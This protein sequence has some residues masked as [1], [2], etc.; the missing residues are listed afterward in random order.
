MASLK[1]SAPL[2][3]LNQRCRQRPIPN[4]AA[5]LLAFRGPGSVTLLW[6]WSRWR[7]QE[8]KGRAAMA[9]ICKER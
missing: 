8:R 3:P 7:E 4:T 5:A 1:I 9:P 2:T 6:V